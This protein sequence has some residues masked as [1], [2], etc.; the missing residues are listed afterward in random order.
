[1]GE[2]MHK[3]EWDLSFGRYDLC[4]LALWLPLV[5]KFPLWEKGIAEIKETIHPRA[6]C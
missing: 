4:Y 2:I 6:F 3:S 1:M 5:Y